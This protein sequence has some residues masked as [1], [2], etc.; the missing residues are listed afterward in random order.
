MFHNPTVNFSAY[1]VN[2]YYFSLSALE[3][4]LLPIA[5]YLLA[6]YQFSYLFN[7]RA[8]DVFASLPVTRAS[9]FSGKM[10]AALLILWVPVWFSLTARVLLNGVFMGFSMPL[11]LEWIFYMVYQPF[12]MII[13]YLMTVWVCTLVGTQIEAVF[14]PFILLL[15]P[16]G[17]CTLSQT[18]L[19]ETIYGAD[20]GI[21]VLLAA[22]LPLLSGQQRQ[23]VLRHQLWNHQHDGGSSAARSRLL[24]GTSLGIPGRFKIRPVDYGDLDGAAHCRLFPVQTRLFG[25]SRWN[26]PA[27]GGLPA[28]FIW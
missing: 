18:I 25:A 28:R 1:L 9:I 11:I 24:S 15:A 12:L 5:G 23:W 4:Y 27:C 26:L 14:Y 20:M 19:N 17:I 2:H 22:A 21:R 13:C 6:I 7:R 3:T 8:V 10:R 16:A